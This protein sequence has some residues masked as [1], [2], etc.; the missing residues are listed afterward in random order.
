MNKILTPEQSARILAES[1]MTPDQKIHVLTERFEKFKSVTIGTLL[2]LRSL[3]EKSNFDYD[4]PMKKIS[5]IVKRDGVTIDEN[6]K[7]ITLPKEVEEMNP[8]LVK[9]WLISNNL[10]LLNSI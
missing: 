4:A 10:A 5:E 3:N 1:Q 8:H 7:T 2:Y 6:N 9:M